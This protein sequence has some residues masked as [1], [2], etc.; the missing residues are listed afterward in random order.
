MVETRATRLFRPYR[1]AALRYIKDQKAFAS[2]PCV[3]IGPRDPEWRE[4]ADWHRNRF[5]ELPWEMKE[6]LKDNMKTATFP[7]RSP[8]LF[9]H[10]MDRPS[11]PRD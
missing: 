11:R 6:V 10:V 8:M 5:G 3:A 4:W 9:E 1:E 2:D 7:C